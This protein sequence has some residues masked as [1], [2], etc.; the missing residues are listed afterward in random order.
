MSLLITGGAGF[1]GSAFLNYLNDCTYEGAVVV[2]SIDSKAKWKNLSNCSNIID[3]VNYKQ[4]QPEAKS[5]Y[6]LL[7][8]Y[9]IKAVVHLGATTSTTETDSDLLWR[10]NVVFS[11]ELIKASILKGCRTI[12]ASSAAVYGDTDDFSESI[13]N[14]L[15]CRPLNPYGWSKKMLDIWAYKNKCFTADAGVV[16]LRFFNVFGPG[17]ES[18]G[19]QA[20]LITKI[21]KDLFEKQ[22]K[23]VNLFHDES[24]AIP[25]GDEQRD[26]LYV[27]DIC[28]LLVWLLDG[29]CEAHGIFNV[30]T[31]RARTWNEVVRAIELGANCPLERQ[32][33]EMPEEIRNQYQYYTEANLTN[34][35]KAGYTQP[36]MTLEAAVAEYFQTHWFSGLGGY[37]R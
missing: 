26:H 34:L 9:N 4:L 22:E 8:S 6:E 27:K 37:W 25:K 33:V 3:I 29:N 32:F 1:I 16:A 23:R 15:K 21:A 10:N 12:Y 28:E 30:G 2:D 18:K 17:E 31:G 13:E 24:S 14:T 35:I 19:S 36:F 11:R 7:D 20:S 5:F